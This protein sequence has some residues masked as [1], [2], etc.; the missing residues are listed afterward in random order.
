MFVWN[1]GLIISL[2]KKKKTRVLFCMYIYNNFQFGVEFL[3]VYGWMYERK[4]K[5]EEDKNKEFSLERL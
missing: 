2:L 1:I 5:K 3:I 4:N